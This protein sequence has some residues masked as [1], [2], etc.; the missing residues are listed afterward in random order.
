MCSRKFKYIS[1]SVHDFPV[2]TSTNVLLYSIWG[3]KGGNIQ[4]YATLLK[5]LYRL[6]GI[7]IKNRETNIMNL[8]HERFQFRLVTMFFYNSF[9]LLDII[10]EYRKFGK[11]EILFEFRRTRLDSFNYRISN[12]KKEKIEIL[13]KS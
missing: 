4:W 3:V 6:K 8:A 13:I 1:L 7:K 2:L 10:I 11:R 9:K 5:N 12:K